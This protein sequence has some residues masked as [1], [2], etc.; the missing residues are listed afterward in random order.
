MSAHIRPIQQRDFE[1]LLQM[2]VEHATFE[3]GVLDLRRMEAE[4]PRA[5]FGPTPRLLCWIAQLAEPV[6]YACATVDYS[7]WSAREF[8]YMDCLFVREGF[9]ADGIG[10]QLFQAVCSE[11]QRRGIDELQW[12]TPDWNVRAA[13]FYCRLG[14]V[15]SAKRRY[16][17]ATKGV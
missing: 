3:G 10:L 8:L 6:G 16:R 15:E 11:A 1:V 12:Q 5:L 13:G 4:L 9:R 7:T 14:A 17:Y 2:C